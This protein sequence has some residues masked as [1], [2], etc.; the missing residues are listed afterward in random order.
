MV[1]IGKPTKDERWFVPLET[2]T[3]IGPEQSAVFT[4]ALRASPSNSKG[5][6]ITL[7]GQ[8]AFR[9][10]KDA[11]RDKDAGMP[12]SK[13]LKRCDWV[14]E[15]QGGPPWGSALHVSERIVAA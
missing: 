7:S 3:E 4:I 10:I 11:D 13:N 9:V 2:Y 14:N 8:I 12:D 1:C 5:E 6:K 15:D